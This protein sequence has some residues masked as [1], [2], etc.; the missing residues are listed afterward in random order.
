MDTRKRKLHN[1]GTHISNSD[2]PFVIIYKVISY[3]HNAK[4]MKLIFLPTNTLSVIII[5]L[6][7]F[8]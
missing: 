8:F 2:G 5:N 6:N 4:T 1:C 3:I 7:Y